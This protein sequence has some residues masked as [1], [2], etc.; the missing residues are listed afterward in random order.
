MYTHVCIYMYVHVLKRTRV[1]I[2][3]SLQR[4]KPWHL[5][6]DEHSQCPGFGFQGSPLTG[7]GPLKRLPWGWAGEE[8]SWD[9]PLCRKVKILRGSEKGSKRTQ[10][11]AERGSRWL[12]REK[13]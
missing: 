8:H 9:S 2:H 6:G 7:P 12:N 13:T 5:E 4:E 11:P 3:F 10:E 1:H